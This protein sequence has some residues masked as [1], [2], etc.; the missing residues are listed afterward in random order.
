MMEVMGWRIDN[1]ARNL[2]MKA[3]N[4]ENNK[5]VFIQKPRS[6]SESLK[7]IAYRLTF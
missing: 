2:F 3:S 5:R 6:R 1:D 7:D 4:N